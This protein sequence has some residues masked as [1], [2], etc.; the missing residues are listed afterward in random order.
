MIL[1]ISAFFDVLSYIGVIAFA[2]SGA[3]VAIDR[4]T[5]IFGVVFLSFLTSFGGGLLRDVFLNR[6]LPLFFTNYTGLII[7][8][9][10]TSLA[11]FF[12]AMIFKDKFIEDEKLLDRI[13]N[14][15]D[16]VGIGVFS[17]SGAKIAIEMGYDTP[18]IAIFMGVITC[19]GGGMLRDIVLRD[20]PFVLR[21]RIYALA[22]IAGSSTYYVLYRLGA[23]DEAAMLAGALTTMTVRILATVF[24][25]NMP[26]AINFSAL[27]A[28]NR[29]NKDKK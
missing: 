4:E 2:I 22:C 25:W 8:C 9:F 17:V 1:E 24:R 12:F 6:G 10:V 3:I 14:Y 5:D 11:V 18:F 16:A 21:K 26:K 19:I 20:V 29:K 23:N 28:E 15:I 7:A 27:R 13:N